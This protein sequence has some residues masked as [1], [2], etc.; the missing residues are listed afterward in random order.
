M[1]EFDA[2]NRRCRSTEILEAQHRSKP[3]LDRSVTLLDQIVEIFGRPDLALI[4]VGL[5]IENLP[6]RAIRSLITIERDLMRRSPLAPERSPEKC[7]GCDV[8]LGAQQKIDGL[9]LF[10]A[11]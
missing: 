3:K 11:R 10:V 2:G 6:G 7:L 1:H 4:S 5:F 8:P 9:S